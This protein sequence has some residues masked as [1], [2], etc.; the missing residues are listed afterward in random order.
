MPL[1]S[2]RAHVAAAVCVV[3]LAMASIMAVHCEAPLTVRVSPNVSVAPTRIRFVATV[4]PHPDN[5]RLCLEYDN[6]EHYSLSCIDI[7]TEDLKPHRFTRLVEEPG[8]YV[9]VVTLLRSTG[10]R[11]VERTQFVVLDGKPTR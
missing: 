1:A 4:E 11:F 7:D 8:E 6:G 2:L 10:Q 5:R 3:G 9:A